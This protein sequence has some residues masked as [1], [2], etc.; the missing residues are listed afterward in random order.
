MEVSLTE[1]DFHRLFD[2]E[3]R[4]WIEQDSSIHLKVVSPFGDPVELTV[5]MAREVAQLLMRLA[6]ELDGGE[7]IPMTGK[8]L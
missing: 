8:R 4:A 3:V 6:D 5:D 1:P 7:H 2:G